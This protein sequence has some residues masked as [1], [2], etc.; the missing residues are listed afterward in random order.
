MRFERPLP[1]HGCIT[2]LTEEQGGRKSGPPATPD[3]QDYAATGFVPPST[4][5]DGL[6]SFVLRVD[7][8]SSWRSFA[9]ASW[10]VPDAGAEVVP[11][12]VVV[13]TE[14]LTTVG[15]FVVDSVN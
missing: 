11:G 9:Y 6:A 8:R 2:W 7:D 12:S 15:Y 4:A 5:E 1:F 13:V 10:L 14:G 3:D